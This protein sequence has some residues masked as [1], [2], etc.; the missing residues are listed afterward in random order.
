MQ[1]LTLKISFVILLSFF[2]H[3]QASAQ[4]TYKLTGVVTDEFNHPLAGATVQMLNT[5]KGA[6]TDRKGAFACNSIARGTYIIQY[7]FLG[8]KSVIDTVRLNSDKNITIKL[9]PENKLLRELTV[10]E[11]AQN[12]HRADNTLSVEI[13]DKKFLQENAAGSLMQTLSRLPGVSSMNIGAGQS[14]P[15][16][17][18][19][20]FNRIAVAENGIKHEAQEWGADHGLEIDQFTVERVEVIKGPASL[21]YGSNAIGGVIDLKQISTPAQHSSGGSVLLNMQSNNNFYGASAKFFK[22]YNHFYYKAHATYADYSDYRI[23]TDSINYMTYNIRLKNNRLRNTAGR[24]RNGSMTMGYLGDGFSTHLSVTNNFSKSGFFANAHGLEIRNSQIDYD[25]SSRDIDL[26]HQQVNHFK[27]LSNTILMI[28]DYKLN[29]DLGYQN[30]YRQEFSERVAHGY[31]PVPPDTLERLYNKHTYSANLKLEFPKHSIHQFTTGLNTDLQKNNSGGWGFMLPDYSALNAGAYVYDNIQLSDKWL[32][33]AGLRYDYGNIRTDAYYDWYKTPQP[34]GSEMNV[35]R[36]WKMN[37]HFA[38][39]SWGIGTSYVSGNTIVKVNAGK[40]FRMPT[41]KEIASNGINYHMYRFEKGD[42]TLKAEESYQLDFGFELKNERWK[43]EFSPFV[44]YF[45][46]YIYLNPTSSYYEAQQVYF[47]SQSSVFRSG[48][49]VVVNYDITRKLS[50]SV[51]A[52]Y[53]YSLQLSGSKKGYTL[54][55]SPP[56]KSNVEFTYKPALKGFFKNTEFGTLITLTAAQYNIVPPEKITPG[57]ILLNFN[58]RT[59][60]AIAKQSFQL[61]MQLNNALNTQYYDHTSFYRLIE[62]P[63]QGRNFIATL[64][65]PLNNKEE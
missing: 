58:A 19:L 26:P 30:N 64:T 36:A 9:C 43:M 28:K 21:M 42:S 54:P 31:M 8:Y 39:F 63:G 62:V 52:E 7:S 22:R 56:M 48:G 59:E 16:I 40:S 33:H 14:K 24:E 27:V 32:L 11:T 4:Q 57:Y 45:P 41:A 25:A 5:N 34:D 37:K 50:M 53:I 12:R 29:I 49:E 65:M 23:P 51:D 6:I 10:S 1:S 3:S 20:G 18:G 46:N 61:S 13:I 55:F 60:F 44:N 17:R 47:Y 2:A 15:A 38:N 35:Q